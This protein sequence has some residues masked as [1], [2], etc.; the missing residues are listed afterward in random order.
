MHAE[1]E[2]DAGSKVAWWKWLGVRSTALGQ[3]LAAL[4]AA[5]GAATTVLAE[6][7]A[8]LPFFQVALAGAAVFLVHGPW[9]ALNRA[10][11][12]AGAKKNSAGGVVQAQQQAQQVEE[13]PQ[14]RG[15]LEQ[16]QGEGQDGEEEDIGVEE[17]VRF[18]LGL[19]VPPW[20]YLMLSVVDVAGNYCAVI[21]YRYTLMTSVAL[22]SNLSIPFTMGLS[23][24]LLGSRYNK[25]HYVGAAT[26]LAGMVVL[27]YADGGGSGS[28]ASDPL[29]GDM[30]LVAGTALYA[31]SNVLSEAVVKSYD[32]VE[33]LACTSLGATV[34]GL[35]G[36]A[37]TG[38]LAGGMP[39]SRGSLTAST[40]WL[41]EISFALI[42]LCYYYLA[43]L[44][45]KSFGSVAL[46]VNLLSTDIWSIVVIS[47]IFGVSDDSKGSVSGL[48][49]FLFFAAFAF[50]AGGIL[51][52]SFL[53]KDPGADLD[54]LA[55]LK[56]L[57]SGDGGGPAIIRLPTTIPSSDPAFRLVDS[58]DDGGGQG[59]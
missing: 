12:R 2:D 13:Q 17:D 50:E 7:G 32:R 11:E 37:V 49:V 56:S 20:C 18:A 8:N 15:H 33:Y 48:F 23:R 19:R 3:C 14:R 35:L 53:G 1:D 9:L 51:V 58:D 25:W 54:R 42:M 38:E 21:A 44:M 6:G 43:P 57:V 16:G 55:W 24:V 4:I 31:T 30:I 41:L 22:I 59:R 28:P 39:P 5:M 46:N 36:A 34:L 26:S 45:L 10:A 52:Y 47:A 40:F 27:L 29:L